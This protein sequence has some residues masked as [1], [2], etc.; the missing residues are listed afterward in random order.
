MAYEEQ[1]YNKRAFEWPVW[2]SILP[3]L[4]PYQKTLL[5]ILTLN[6][7]CA[8][9]DILMPLFQRYAIDH[10]IEARTSSGLISFAAAYA[11]VIVFQTVSVICF[12]RGCMRVEMGMGRD[13]KRACFVHMQTLSFSYFNITPVGYILSRIMSD[14]NRI[15]GLMAWN[16]I[17]ILWAL[18]YVLGVFAAML[19]LNPALALPV[20]LVVPVIAVLTAYFQN[21][22]LHWNRKIRKAHSHV[23]SAYNEG[24]MGAKTS[25]A[26]V[27]EEQN[28]QEFQ[29][30]SNG[31]RKASVRSSQL[32]AIYIPLVMFC[33][34]LATAIVLARGGQMVQE[35]LIQ[36]GTLSA[37][38]SYAIGIFEPIQQLARTI[39][40]AI[41]VQANIERVTGPV[42]YTH[43]TLPTTPYV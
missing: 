22:I 16:L 34:S 5:V 4:K 39:A 33:S 9:I 8:A 27:I 32:S 18:F 23:T 21:R 15:A 10:F 6:L 13:L 38:T 40:E 20:I 29:G 11:G 25:K 31:L 42:S 28:Y 30:V 17:D 3:Y 26:L 24:I 2:K 14:T 19:V 43:L 37:F 35:N 41:S 12:T 36:I 7:A 1:D